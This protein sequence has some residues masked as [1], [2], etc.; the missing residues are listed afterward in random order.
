MGLIQKDFGEHKMYLIKGDPGISKTLQKPHGYKK[1]E[2]EFM[3]LIREQLKAG[4]IACD[5]G[6]NIG[7]ATLIMA[8]LVGKSG[9]VY[10]IEPDPKN[11]KVLR[12]NIEL[13]KYSE[14]VSLYHLGISDTDGKLPFARSRKSNLGSFGKV[15]NRIGTVTVDVQTI[16]SMFA[17]KENLPTFYKMDVEGHEVKVLRGMRKTAKRSPKDTKILMEVHPQLFNSGDLNFE[18]ELRAMMDL[19]FRFK[20]VISAAIAQP[21]LFKDRGYKPKRVYESSGW[22][23]GVYDD[24]TDEDAIYFCSKSHSEYVPVRKRTTKKIVRAIMLEKV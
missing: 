3:T 22:H 15:K 14:R 7:Y 10:A 4:E 12:Q 24:V 18:P 17:N 20:Y 23:R 5:I 6:A 19:G 9:H 21:Q 13:N 2:I 8:K 1:R 16:D 11:I